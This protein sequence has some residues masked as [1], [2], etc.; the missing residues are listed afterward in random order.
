MRNSWMNGQLSRETS[1][2]ATPDLGSTLNRLL[3]TL[4]LK[5]QLKED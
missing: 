5:Q 2:P 4:M 1:S 3:G